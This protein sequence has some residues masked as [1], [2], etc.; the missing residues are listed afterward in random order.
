MIVVDPTNSNKVYLGAAQGGV[1]RSLDGG[2]TWT[3]IF[4]TAQSLSI[5][6]LALAPSD[7]TK[8]YVGTGEPN[9]SADSFFGV[10][11]YRIDNADTTADLVG[12]I[13]PS[14]TTGTTTA[15]TYNCFNGRGISRILVN[16][17]DPAT[18]FVST[19]TGVGGLGGNALSNTIPPLALRGVFRSTNATAAAGSVTFT[20]LIVNT[21]GS[22]DNPGTGNTSIFDMVLEPGN[23]NNLLVA[24]SGASTGGGVWRSTNALAAT[25]TFVN[26]LFPGFNGLVHKLAIN[27]VGAVVTV[28]AS[29]NETSFPGSGCGSQ[30]GRV[31]KSTDGGVSWS[32]P[33]AAAEGYC[34]GQCSYDNPIGVDPNNANIVYLGGNAHGSC[35]DVLKRSSD[36]GTTFTR[37]DT[38]L[39]ADAHAISFDPLTTPTTVWFANDGGIWKRGDAVAGT[40]WLTQN[41]G[42]LGTIQFQSVAV[43]PT[44]Q[45]FTIGGTQV[46]V[47]ESQQTTRGNWLSAGRGDGG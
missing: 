1:W 42:P 22:L 16:P 7:P 21:D 37:D 18:I 28:F 4:D 36:G 31:R 34:G 9:N 40:A 3:P 11:V 14:I 44:D 29:S 19:A 26:T 17:T 2:L 46:N 13:N 27:K 32:A 38:G 30:S 12:P 10:G 47:T 39:H 33:L 15:L 41:N 5:G 20:K 45:N 35:S 23:A 25:P 8:L 43:H 24:P 6:A